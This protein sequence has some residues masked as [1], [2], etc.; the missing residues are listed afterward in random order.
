MLLRRCTIVSLFIIGIA[1]LTGELI[2]H[3]RTQQIQPLYRISLV[4]KSNP[5]SANSELIDQR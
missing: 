3:Q 4:Q 1:V 5:Q 2:Q